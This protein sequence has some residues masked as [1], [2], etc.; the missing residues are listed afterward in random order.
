MAKLE[1]NCKNILGVLIS[2]RSER[3]RRGKSPDLF[4]LLR[5]LL[6]RPSH[7]GPLEGL[8]SGRR[9]FPVRAARVFLQFGAWDKP[10]L[11][12]KHNRRVS[13][14]GFLGELSSCHCSFSHSGG[15]LMLPAARRTI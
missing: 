12:P 1:L 9:D 13:G 8:Q 11:E 14:V 6:F 7:F 10:L 5:R 3:M 4:A 2:Q 15:K